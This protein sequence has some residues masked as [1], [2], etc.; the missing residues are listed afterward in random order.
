I[1]GGA[2]IHNGSKASEFIV[3]NTVP[4]LREKDIL[5]EHNADTPCKRI[6]LAIQLMYIDE[7]K[8]TEYHHAYWSL[9]RDVV[10]AAPSTLPLIDQISEQILGGKYYQAIKLAKNLIEY[11]QE[12]VNNVRKSAG[13]L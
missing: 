4:I 12:V 3:E 8:L 1:I 2:V 6:Y 9:V 7:K 5:S 10:A 11:E 13:N